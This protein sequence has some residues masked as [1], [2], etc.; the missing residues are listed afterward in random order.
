MAG[1]RLLDL[2]GRGDRVADERD[3]GAGEQAP[4]APGPE[5]WYAMPGT[6]YDAFLTFL[7]RTVLAGQ[8]AQMLLGKLGQARLAQPE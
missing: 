6:D 5:A 4:E 3:E 2:T 8:E 1:G 7:Q